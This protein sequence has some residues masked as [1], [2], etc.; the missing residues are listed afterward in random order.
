MDPKFRFRFGVAALLLVPAVHPLLMPWAGVASHLLWWIHVLPVAMLGYRYGR[1][2]LG[3]SIA[4]SV[5][6]LVIGERAF[7]AGYM[8]AADWPTVV[9]LAVA[10]SFTEILVG[11][12]ALYA[13]GMSRRYRL[14]FDEADMGIIRTDAEGRVVQ[15]NPAAL[16]LLGLEAGVLAGD[17]LP[18]VAVFESLPPL[19]D[20]EARGGW[21][22]SLERH[23]GRVRHVL[24]AA[25]GQDDPRGHQVLIMDRTTEVAREL[26]EERQRKLATLGEALAGVAHELK[27]PL[28]VILAESELALTDSSAGTEELRETVREVGRQ[29]R[30]MREL[31]DELLGFS[32]GPTSG[33]VELSAVL[34]RLLRLEEMVHG[35]KVRWSDEIHWEGEMDVPA[36]RV[37]QIVSNLLSNAAEAMGADGGRGELR[38]WRED[39]TVHV[40][41]ADRGPGVPPDV[42][43]RLFSPFFTT[44][45]DEGGTGLGLAI[46]RRLAI[47]LGGDLSARNRPSGGAAFRLT[48]PMDASD[49][50]PAP[51]T[52]GPETRSEPD[53]LPAR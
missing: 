17:R 49:A 5:I 12:F 11:G 41:V 14:L 34:R 44:R 20:L 31:V 9:S 18:E 19:E 42:M 36:A 38:C 7:G 6:L 35:K 15:V 1:T 40:E 33:P 32:R 45:A 8:V 27:N 43:D 47:A 16:E 29:G 53:I 26:E 50:G 2:A 4:G 3:P 30:R 23:D 28:T 46:S 25:V 52:P 24:I 21:T 37:E 10:L 39:E 13:R 22:G 48:L 51:A